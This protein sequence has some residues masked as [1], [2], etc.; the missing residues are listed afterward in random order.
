[1]ILNACFT[2][3]YEG[4]NMTDSSNLPIPVRAALRKLGQDISDA[5]RRRRISTLL[6][7]ERAGLSRATLSKIEKGDATVS[8]GGYAAV[9]FVLGLTSRLQDMA[10]A[11]HDLTGRELADEALPKRI[12]GKRGVK[13]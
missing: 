5:R 1:M 12:Y 4:K 8:L 9:L 7:A 10:D 2:R 13:K 3:H 6:M 11:A